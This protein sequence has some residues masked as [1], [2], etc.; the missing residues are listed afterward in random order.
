MGTNGFERSLTKKRSMNNIFK[1]ITSLEIL[2]YLILVIG[3]FMISISFNLFLCPNN[4][5]SGG[6]PGLS[7]VLHKLFGINTAYIQLGINV[8][9]FC[10]GV[11]RCGGK[12]GLKTA[13][14]SFVIP[15]FVLLTQ[16]FPIM[17]HNL[18]IAS[19]LGGAGVGVGLG[20]VFK[21][22]GSVGGFSLLAKIMHDYTKI[23]LSSLVL[24]LNL[25]VI[26]LAGL[27][28]NFA[29]AFYALISLAITCI[30]IDVALFGFNV[31]QRKNRFKEN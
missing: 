5:A 21:S 31:F 3:C 27:T 14:G 24:M 23:K 17:S 28:F 7:V 26:L 30:F 8:P 13:L 9:L 6:I 10:L 18:F 25:A 19:I 22:N 4:I 20:F 16:G 1:A 12:F 2:E 29:G 11:L 15:V